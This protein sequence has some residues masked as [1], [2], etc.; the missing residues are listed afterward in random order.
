MRREELIA[1]YAPPSTREE[2]L[3]LQVA[4]T[5]LLQRH[6]LELAART[7]R[8]SGGDPTIYQGDELLAKAGRPSD[9]T[10]AAYKRRA[11]PLWRAALASNQSVWDLALNRSKTPGSWYAA[12]AAL[13]RHLAELLRECKR[14]VDSTLRSQSSA[15]TVS[16]ADQAKFKRS[17]VDLA[18]LANALSSLPAGGLPDKFRIPGQK[19][20]ERASKR[21]SLKGLRADWQQVLCEALPDDRRLPWL[22][23]CVTGCRPA[24]L[25][26][27]VQI[28]LRTD[29]SLEIHI[30]GAKV[31]ERSGQP[32]RGMLFN[33]EDASTKALV[34]CLNGR[35][36][37]QYE[38]SGSVDAYRKSISHY[39]KK[40][41][42]NQKPNLQPSAYSARHQFKG[43]MAHA[44]R[45]REVVAKSLGHATT[46]SATYY[47]GSVARSGQVAP[48]AVFAT[49]AVKHR[50]GPPTRKAAATSTSTSLPA[51]KLVTKP[52]NK[53][54]NKPRL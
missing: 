3:A 49:R 52:V 7:I 35:G 21:H 32:L 15:T 50:E 54:M 11:H 48:K 9:A 43:V 26:R 17:L 41:F 45:G 36:R 33:V 38:L 46:K 8:A 22:I 28:V 24:E 44:G 5:E 18:H 2:L 47:G 34:G 40:L 39:C 23:Q 1:T 4:T 14:S 10:S 42:P 29:G 27:G 51:H 30:R 25:K 20:R 53:L 31:R 6:R 37:T 16:R 12:R 13:Q 19:K